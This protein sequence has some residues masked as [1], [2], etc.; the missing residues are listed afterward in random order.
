MYHLIFAGLLVF[1]DGSC[2]IKRRP[3]NVDAGQ[4]VWF[5]MPEY[6]MEIVESKLNAE[7]IYV[8]RTDEYQVQNMENKRQ[9]INVVFEQVAEDVTNLLDEFTVMVTQMIELKDSDISL[10]KLLDII[11]LTVLNINSCLEHMYDNEANVTQALNRYL[12]LSD[13]IFLYQTEYDKDTDTVT[14]IDTPRLDY[15]KQKIL[16][17]IKMK[18]NIERPTFSV[19]ILPEKSNTDILAEAKKIIDE[20]THFYDR[21]YD[22]LWLNADKLKWK[23]LMRSTMVQNWVSPVSG[24]RLQQRYD[25]TAAEVDSTKVLAFYA[26]VAETVTVLLA[27]KASGAFALFVDYLL[28]M[29]ASGSSNNLIRRQ[30]LNAVIAVLSELLNVLKSSRDFMLSVLNLECPEGLLV[31]TIA[32]LDCVIKRGTEVLEKEVSEPDLHTL[33]EYVSQRFVKPVNAPDPAV[34]QPDIAVTETQA[35]EKLEKIINDIK[36][37]LSETSD[38]GKVLL[39]QK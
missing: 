28:A 3:V 16:D 11:Q 14:D 25:D 23:D 10:K 22:C 1:S 27:Q 29:V 2:R 17:L 18:T 7:V 24:K 6:L 32:D 35:P 31:T 39:L 34:E 33:I 12:F 26:E 37:I 21:K 9:T 4:Q 5:N 15:E 20:Y 19:R 38:I 30:H 36:V 8:Q 13:M